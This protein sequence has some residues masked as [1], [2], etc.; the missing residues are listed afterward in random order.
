VNGAALTQTY[1]PGMVLSVFGSQLA[2]SITAASSVPLPTSVAGVDA[3]VNRVA[4]PLYYVSP[5][6]LNLQ[7]PYET[8]ANGTA[9]LQINNTGQSTSQTFRVAAA[10]PGIFTDQSGAIVPDGSAARGQI[11]TLYMTGAG[12]MTPRIPTGE[13]AGAETSIADLPKPVQTTTMTIGGVPTPVDFIGAHA[14]LVGVT[15]VKFRIPDAVGIGAQ[16]VIVTVGGIS[17]APAI[18]RVTQ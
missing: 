7:I 16:S 11:T 8:A 5:A 10:A 15:E 4:A 9:T 2:P 13:A 14:G 17:S 12:S 6:Q 3:A 1:A 18:L